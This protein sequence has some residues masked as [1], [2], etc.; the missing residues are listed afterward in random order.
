MT[1]VGSKKPM[2]NK[3]V[4]IK[5][6]EGL[7]EVSSNR[8]RNSITLKE[9][10]PYVSV[11][12]YSFVSLYKDGVKKN[13]LVHRLVAENLIPNPEGKE[14]VD[15]INRIKHDNRVE[16]LRWATKDEQEF[17][18]DFTPRKIKCS[19]GNVYSSLGHA[20]EELGLN[21]SKICAVCR[22]RRKTH[23]GLSFEYYN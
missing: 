9:L 3:W 4:P 23:G 7:Y 20:A 18:K 21:K 10:K 12:G 6:Y 8:V 5:G 17:N 2:Q 19:N 14:T 22:G 1:Q 11:K 16:N 15:H 13:I